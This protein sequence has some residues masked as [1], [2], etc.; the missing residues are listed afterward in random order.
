RGRWDVFR[1]TTAALALL[2]GGPEPQLHAHSF[3][4]FRDGAFPAAR[5]AA[6]LR[7]ALELGA[8]A[9]AL[10]RPAHLEALRGALQAAGVPVERLAETGQLLLLDAEAVFEAAWA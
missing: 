2:R 3:E 4:L 7:V 5:I 10:A 1:T 6:T 9:G 8:A